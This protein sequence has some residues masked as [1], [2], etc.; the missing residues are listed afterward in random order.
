MILKGWMLITGAT[1]RE[2]R[3]AISQTL[4]AKLRAMH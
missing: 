4:S 2:A 1:E 3:E